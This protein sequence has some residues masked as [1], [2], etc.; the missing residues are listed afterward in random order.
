LRDWKSESVCKND[1]GFAC[2]RD[3]V[4]QRRDGILFKVSRPITTSTDLA[5]LDGDNRSLWQPEIWQWE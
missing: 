1:G 5:L 2:H 4:S 3:K